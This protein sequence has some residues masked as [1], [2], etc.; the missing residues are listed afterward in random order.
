MVN[1]QIHYYTEQ[2]V[3]FEAGQPYRDRNNNVVDLGMGKP[4][5]HFWFSETEYHNR[6][7]HICTIYTPT[8][9]GF[10]EPRSGDCSLGKDRDCTGYSTGQD[11]SEYQRHCPDVKYLGEGVIKHI[12]PDAAR[13]AKAMH[14]E[15]KHVRAY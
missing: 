9:N 1:G 4:V 7:M 12:V 5:F 8:Q 15:L 3:D 11:I 14:I 2:V 6:G 10:M 13:K